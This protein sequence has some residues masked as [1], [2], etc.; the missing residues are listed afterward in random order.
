MNSLLPWNKYISSLSFVEWMPRVI[1]AISALL[2]REWASSHMRGRNWMSQYL[3]TKHFRLLTNV[4]SSLLI[5]CHIANMH[6]GCQCC[7]SLASNLSGN[8]LSLN[9]YSPHLARFIILYFC[10]QLFSVWLRLRR[11]NSLSYHKCRL[12]DFKQTQPV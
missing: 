3:I 5:G 9:I 4:Y 6:I 10:L 12:M 8:N 11:V 7:A 1:S 2:Q